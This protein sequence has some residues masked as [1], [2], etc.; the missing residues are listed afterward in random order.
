MVKGK[1]ALKRV[2]CWELKMQKVGSIHII[3]ATRKI[4]GKL[5]AYV[6]WH[7]SNKE[8]AVNFYHNINHFE[9]IDESIPEADI[10]V[11]RISPF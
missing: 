10:A 2:G 3:I 7:Y 11:L 4:E 8:C 5:Y 9:D 6:E 1:V